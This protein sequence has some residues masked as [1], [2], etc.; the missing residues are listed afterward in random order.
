MPLPALTTLVLRTDDEEYRLN[1]I[2]RALRAR[3]RYGLFDWRIDSRAPGVRVRAH[4]H[5]PASAF[6]ALRYDDPPG[7]AKTCL[8]SKLAACEVRLDVAG[9]APRTFTTALRAAFEILTGRSDHGLAI[10][11]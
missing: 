8:N 4:L 11:A 6:I 10:A 3:G 1:G 7:G 9:R 5:A 2:W